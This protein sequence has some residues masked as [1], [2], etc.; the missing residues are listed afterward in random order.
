MVN[1]NHFYHENFSHLDD[2]AID[3]ESDESSSSDT[4]DDGEEFSF[5]QIVQLRKI[6]DVDRYGCFGK[7]CLFLAAAKHRRWEELLKPVPLYHNGTFDIQ[8]LLFVIDHTPTLTAVHLAIVDENYVECNRFVIQLLHY[9]FVKKSE[10]MLFTISDFKFQKLI[11]SSGVTMNGP[12]PTDVFDL[13][14]DD[15]LEERP[16]LPNNRKFGFYGASPARFYSILSNGY[17]KS[18]KS[19]TN[20]ESIEPTRIHLTSDFSASLSHSDKEPYWYELSPGAVLRCVALC[21]YKDH[22]DC[23]QYK[24]DS[25]QKYIDIFLTKGAEF[26]IWLIMFFKEVI[27]ALPPTSTLQCHSAKLKSGK[28]IKL[29][30]HQKFT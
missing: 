6:F 8:R 21:E 29:E 26:R 28:R 7:W 25:N 11:K 18:L 2:L 16:G 4:E 22:P 19:E 24:K 27:P 9:V 3:D 14:V 12:Y 5:R 15:D 20:D 30:S 23:V 10:P 17:V 13:Q 1:A